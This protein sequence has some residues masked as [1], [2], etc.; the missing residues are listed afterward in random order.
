R[1]AQKKRDDTQNSTKQL[2]A[3][4]RTLTSGKADLENLFEEANARAEKLNTTLSNTRDS[5]LKDA[6]IQ[7]ALDAEIRAIESELSGLIASSKGS[8]TKLDLTASHLQ[9]LEAR[10]KEYA[11]LAEELKKRIR[12]M[13]KLGKEEEKR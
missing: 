7:E 8:S 12:E 10:H 1:A 9:S 4:I 2:L 5:L 6:E 3:K 11:N 13:E